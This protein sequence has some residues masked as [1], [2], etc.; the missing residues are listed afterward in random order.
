M[1]RSW[2]P[3]RRSLLQRLSEDTQAVP[4][5]KGAEE[6]DPVGAGQLSLDLAADAG[7]VSAIDEEGAGSERGFWSLG[8]LDGPGDADGFDDG[9]EDVPGL[10]D[11]LLGQIG[12]GRGG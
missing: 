11:E 3:R 6:V 9:A 12:G 4:F 10:G 1:T 8:E 2:P 7:L 5:D